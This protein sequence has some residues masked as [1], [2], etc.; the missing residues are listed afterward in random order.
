MKKET[1]NFNAI[2]TFTDVAR[3]LDN[4]HSEIL[5]LYNESI[6]KIPFDSKSFKHKLTSPEK[7]Q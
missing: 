3:M 1:N 5:G 4:S 7:T 6:A 2:S